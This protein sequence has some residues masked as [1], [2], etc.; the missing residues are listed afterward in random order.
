V[1][2]LLLVALVGAGLLAGTVPD[3][4]AL[5]GL[6]ALHLLF[7]WLYHGPGRPTADGLLRRHLVLLKYPALMMLMSPSG[8]AHDLP[9][10]GCV[11][12]IVGLLFA[13]HETADDPELGFGPRATG[14]YLAESILLSGLVATILFPGATAMEWGLLGT[15]VLFA[16]MVA[17]RGRE[18]RTV[19]G[20]ATLPFLLTGILLVGSA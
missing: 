2:F 15:Q 4:R 17:A 20:A 3:R 13:L 6:L 11:G 19:P 14:V 10:A 9:V 1:I 7:A 5:G 18:F 12:A 8:V 16:G